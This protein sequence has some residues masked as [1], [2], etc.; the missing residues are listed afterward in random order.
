MGFS[1]NPRVTEEM[2]VS[3]KE[4][5]FTRTW[6]PISHR[7]VVD[8]MEKATNDLGIKVNRRQYS[9]SEDG[10]QMYGAWT[11]KDGKIKKIG[12]DSVFQA[13]IFR[14]ALN[15]YYSFGMNAATDTWLCENLMV[16]GNFIEFKRHTGDLDDDRLRLV[17]NS[18]LEKLAGRLDPTLE[19]HRKMKEIAITE[20]EC[21][22]L[23]YDA[24]QMKVISQKRLPVFNQL[25]FGE[26]NEYNP[27]VLWGFHGA[28]TQLMRELS[29]TG[30]FQQKQDSL[31]GLISSRYGHM[32]PVI[33][34]E[35]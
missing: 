13:I 9:L 25:L 26:S 18:G 12:K 1:I 30:G 4:P 11:L 33:E 7:R 20:L 10:L 32:L 8:V 24:I 14:N 6:H 15:K 16:L 34:Y 5:E 17:V 27:K 28:C 35:R 19:W 3:V 22:S 31:H 2:V 21:K 29:M 23:A